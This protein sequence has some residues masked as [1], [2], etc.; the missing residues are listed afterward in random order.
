MFKKYNHIC[1]KDIF[2]GALFNNNTV[3]TVLNERTLETQIV[4]LADIIGAIPMMPYDI[5]ITYSQTDETRCSFTGTI[6][7]GAGTIDVYQTLNAAVS[8]NITYY[9]VYDWSDITTKLVESVSPFQMEL[10]HV[11]VQNNQIHSNNYHNIYYDDHVLVDRV[12]SLE[13]RMDNAESDITSLESRMSTA[14]TDIN[15]LESRMT[16]AENDIDG[17]DT[18]LTTAESNI[19]SND[20]EIDGLKS[21][22][23]T[24]EGDIGD[25]E[26]TVNG[27]TYG[28]QALSNKINTLQTSVTGL[29]TRVTTIEDNQNYQDLEEIASEISSQN[30]SINT[31]NQNASNALTRANTAVSYMNELQ[32]TFNEDQLLG[33]LPYLITSISSVNT[34]GCIKLNTDTSNEYYHAYRINFVD[35]SGL[36]TNTIGTLRV[37]KTGYY[38]INYNIFT[39]SSGQWQNSNR[40]I[41]VDVYSQTTSTPLYSTYYA[42]NFSQ[43]NDNSYNISGTFYLNLVSGLD[44]DIT[45]ATGSGDAGGILNV[46]PSRSNLRIS[47]LGN[48]ING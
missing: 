46:I 43:S 30:A 15:N 20:N 3:Q 41:A 42:A 40:I 36:T 32:A 21:R 26:D 1:L 45:I 23:T 10:W 11:N 48:Y 14:E 33:Q 9:L 35:D 12:D 34:N 18:R 31:A 4:K 37:D 39:A 6:R 38:A 28:N 13:S 17:L 22:M 16:T 44:I 27:D 8:E 19:T 25:L 24:A 2:P 47:Y 29:N 5:E 7:V